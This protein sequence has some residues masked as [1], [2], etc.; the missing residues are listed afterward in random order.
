[1]EDDGAPD[2]AKTVPNPT[3]RPEA[4]MSSPV[5]LETGYRILIAEDERIVAM[6]LCEMLEGL[7][8]EVVGNVSTAE[9]V[10]RL[11]S[12]TVPD[13]VL[14]DISLAGP[15]DG[16]SAA[17]SIQAQGLAP[18]VFLTAYSDS[19]TLRRAAEVEPYGY[20]MKPLQERELRVGIEVAVARFRAEQARQEAA[21]ETES[22]PTDEAGPGH[23]L[24]VCSWCGRIYS[25]A[26]GW[27]AG[28]SRTASS[29]DSEVTHQICPDCSSKERERSGS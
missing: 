2:T 22:P 28:D 25:D 27:I 8:Y 26:E 3:S 12:E 6:A 11:T 23:P 9:E 4:L 14:M 10:T 19:R 15:Q 17:G 1:M 13:V 20:L 24:P 29:F 16:I 5:R 7:G 18:V 21:G